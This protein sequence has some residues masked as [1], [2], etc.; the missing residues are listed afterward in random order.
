MDK[1]GL[2]REDFDSYKEYKKEYNKLHKKTDAYKKYCE[3]RKE[4]QKEYLKEYRTRPEA[5]ER[6]KEYQR[7]YRKNNRGLINAKT[8]R[9]RASKNNRTPS[10]SETE[11][12]KEFY[13]NCP[14]GCEVD[15]I[16]PLQGEKVSGLHVIG[17]LQYLTM[18][19]NRVKSN[20]LVS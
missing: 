16:I 5:K 6:K 17:N 10:W 4:Q 12:I 13:M 1:V 8:S 3:S 9:Y 2:N 20:K 19:E 15:H 7:K 18:H 11:L 14:K